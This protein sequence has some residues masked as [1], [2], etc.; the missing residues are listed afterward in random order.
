MPTPI[1][2]IVSVLLYRLSVVVCFLSNL[3]RQSKWLGLKLDY[4]E[5]CF[6]S[7]LCTSRF[8]PSLFDSSALISRQDIEMYKNLL[9]GFCFCRVI[10]KNNIK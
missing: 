3:K 2:I 4:D 8:S 5:L 9:G 10:Q 1:D 6:G 7:R